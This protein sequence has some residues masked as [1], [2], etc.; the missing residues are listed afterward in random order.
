M[1]MTP[2]KRE[3]LN[4]IFKKLNNELTKDQFYI[5]LYDLDK[6]YPIKGH[7][8]P[9]SKESMRNYKEIHENKII[10]SYSFKDEY[11]NE[12]KA[13]LR[14]TLQPLSFKESAEFYMHHSQKVDEDEEA[15]KP[16]K[17][18]FTLKTKIITNDPN[19]FERKRNLLEQQKKELRV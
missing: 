7:F 14:Q 19:E 16:F 15:W 1:E 11:G 6:K 10:K 18:P 4:L 12:F 9:L 5:A 13:E 8:P 3:C 17:K 2:I